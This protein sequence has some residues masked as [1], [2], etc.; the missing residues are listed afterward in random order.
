P[1]GF[2]TMEEFFEIL[3][4]AQL[5]LHQKPIGLLNSASFY[6]D[7]LRMFQKMTVVDLLKKSNLKLLCVS[8]NCKELLQKM[9][10]YEPQP[11]PKW[12]HEDQT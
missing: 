1:G 8:E 7:L 6:D 9:E 11:V 12:L 3:T 5:G 10:N 4:W 2:G